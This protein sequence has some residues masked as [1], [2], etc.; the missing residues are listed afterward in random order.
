M[1]SYKYSVS[2]I[3]LSFYLLLVSVV[4]G[5]PR[6]TGSPYR[7]LLGLEKRQDDDPYDG[8]APDIENDD[9]E[10]FADTDN[11]RNGKISLLL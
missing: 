1:V 6:E 7:N 3:G 9:P 11:L 4:V 5:M 10:P 2:I 8:P